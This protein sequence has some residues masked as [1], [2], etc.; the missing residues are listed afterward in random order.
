MKVLMIGGT[1]NISS[2]ITRLLLARGDDVWLFNRGTR[3]ELEVLG[4]K[5]I[6]GDLR[7]PDG[8]KTGFAMQS[9]SSRT[10]YTSHGTKRTSN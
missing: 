8:M 7:D 4:A 3:R 9:A 5:Y 10:S 6:V 2:S 1:G